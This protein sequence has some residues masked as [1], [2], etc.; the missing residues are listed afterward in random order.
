MKL[1]PLVVFVIAALPFRSAS[2]SACPDNITRSYQ[3]PNCQCGKALLNLTASLS[4][5][6]RV[7]AAC[8]LRFAE[9]GVT[10][11]DLRK[12]KLTLDTFIPGKILYGDFF[13]EGQVTVS[14]EF[15]YSPGEGGD[16]WFTPSPP[17][18]S[19]N[20]PALF[21]YFNRL[22]V[23]NMV[24]SLPSSLQNLECFTSNAVIKIDGVRLMVGDSYEAGA[25]PINVNL[26]KLGKPRRCSGR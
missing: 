19:P 20:F 1:T 7:I 5:P 8:D 11:I 9:D 18:V 23:D 10:Q 21:F 26:I 12:Q 6:F 13:V 14:G 25:Y 16:A 22:K 24:T 15:L 4:H 17:L 3:E 2:G